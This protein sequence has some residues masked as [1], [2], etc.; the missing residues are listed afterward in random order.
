MILSWNHV[1][2]FIVLRQDP[3]VG[4]VEDFF[5]DKVTRATDVSSHEV[6]IASAVIACESNV[7]ILLSSL[8]LLL[9]FVFWDQVISGERSGQDGTTRET[10]GRMTCPHAASFIRVQYSRSPHF[11]LSMKNGLHQMPKDHMF[12]QSMTRI[13]LCLVFGTWEIQISYGL[14]QTI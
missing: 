13:G 1:F 12:N 3:F 8:L 11:A 14:R 5:R 4:S 7:L 6:S 9:L 10:D 2:R